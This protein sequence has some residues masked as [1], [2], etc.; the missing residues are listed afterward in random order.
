MAIIPVVQRYFPA[1]DPSSVPADLQDEFEAFQHRKL[2]KITAPV[3][4]LGTFILVALIGIDVFILPDVIGLSLALRAFFGIPV[5]VLALAWLRQ[6]GHP[7]GDD[8]LRAVSLALA[9]ATSDDELVARYGGE[10]FG[11]VMPQT[12][13]LALKMVGA[14]LRTSVEKLQIE[15]PA[16]PTGKT[17]SVSIGI[18]YADRTVID[19]LT[20]VELIEA[21][22]RALYRAK[23]E[24]RNRAV[25]AAWVCPSDPEPQSHTPRRHLANG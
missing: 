12:N 11:V 16:S 18:A 17:V 1:F 6:P 19:Q 4:K 8:A 20:P 22:D 5:A 21:A 2:D 7:A 3:L 23:A 9:S 25:I 24:G 14:R 15:H 10:E 13:P